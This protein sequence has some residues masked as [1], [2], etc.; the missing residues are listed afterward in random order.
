MRWCSNNSEIQKATHSIK[1]HLLIKKIAIRLIDRLRV[2]PWASSWRRSVGAAVA[3]V[4]SRLVQ[5]W[6]R[7]CCK[8]H[9]SWRRRYRLRSATRRRRSWW[10]VRRVS[11]ERLLSWERLPRILL[12]IRITSLAWLT[13]LSTSARTRLTR[14]RRTGSILGREGGRSPSSTPPRAPSPHTRSTD[15]RIP[16]IFRPRLR[17]RWIIRGIWLIKQWMIRRRIRMCLM[18]IAN[19]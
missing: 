18:I 7:R 1:I 3:V 14:A 13:K 9:G 10:V 19:P 5:V 15:R 4:G 16:S 6:R 12:I 17:V 11:W 8:L 2:G